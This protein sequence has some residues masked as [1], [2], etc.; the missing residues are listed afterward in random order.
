MA[1]G[2]ENW[3]RGL[4][5]ETEEG[6][7]MTFVARVNGE[8]AGYTSPHTIDG[9][10]R[11]GALYVSPKAQG[12][13]VGTKLLEKAVAWH[14]RERDV[15]LHVLGYN[16]NAINFYERFGFEKTGREIPDEP[17]YGVTLP[18]EIEIVLRADSKSE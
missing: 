6:E 2:I 11:I 15:F 16:Q 14:G 3:Q 12:K 18:P 9:Q 1:I 8:I 17:E 5:G 7:R 10:R 4:A 13:G